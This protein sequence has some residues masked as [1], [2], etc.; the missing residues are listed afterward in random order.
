LSQSSGKLY[1]A[2]LIIKRAHLFYAWHTKKESSSLGLPRIWLGRIQITKRT[3]LLLEN[4]ML[5]SRASPHLVGVNP[6]L[7]AVRKLHGSILY[8]IAGCI[9]NWSSYDLTR[10]IGD[11]TSEIYVRSNL[12]SYHV[13]GFDISYAVQH[14]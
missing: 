5:L 9:N 12:N 8:M 14:S 13:D 2:F 6:D 11:F 4:L 3:C 1:P 10:F 7:F